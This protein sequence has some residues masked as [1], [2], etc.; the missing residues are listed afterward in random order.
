MFTK[1]CLRLLSGLHIL[2][3]WPQHQLQTKAKLRSSFLWY[4]S[5]F[6]FAYCTKLDSKLFIFFGRADAQV[7][8]NH[9]CERNLNLAQLEIITL[10]DNCCLES[11]LSEREF[12]F[13]A[14]KSSNFD[15]N[16]SSITI[17][18]ENRNRKIQNI[19]KLWLID[20]YFRSFDNIWRLIR[21]SWW[22]NLLLNQIFV[23][24]L[25]MFD[26][27]CLVACFEAAIFTTIRLC[28]CESL[29]IKQ[30]I[31]FVST[32]FRS[33]LCENFCDTLKYCW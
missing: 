27:C 22:K 23:H 18:S 1:H 9:C 28:T 16:Y 26:H 12:A 33:Y 20:F 5:R 21:G 25:L 13:H 10:T 6:L 24:I 17:S 11:D 15:E 7:Q 14:T 32:D 8:N 2:N 30:F 29:I 19:D 3:F 4:F 31:I